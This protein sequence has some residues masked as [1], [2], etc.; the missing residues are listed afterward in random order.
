MS[1]DHLITL[2]KPY[3]EYVH[4][5]FVEHPKGNLNFDSSHSVEGAR[6]FL[7]P[8]YDTAS[9]MSRTTLDYSGVRI[10][11]NAID[12]CRQLFR[13]GVHLDRV[14]QLENA[15]LNDITGDPIFQDE[16]LLGGL[17][18]LLRRSPRGSG[19]RYCL[20]NSPMGIQI[21]VCSYFMPYRKKKLLEEC[22]VEGR[23][24]YEIIPGTHLKIQIQPRILNHYTDAQIQELFESVAN[25]FMISQPIPGNETVGLFWSYLKCEIHL[26]VDF[27][28]W[29]PTLDFLGNMVC[30]TGKLRLDESPNFV[31]FKHHAVVYGKEF[32]TATLGVREL[33]QFSFYRKDLRAIK[34]G[35]LGYW[36]DL[37]KSKCPDFDPDMKVW[38][39]ELRFHSNTIDTLSPLV[40]EQHIAENFIDQQTH[41]CNHATLEGMEIRY[42][43]EYKLCSF[44]QVKNYL[45]AFWRYGLTKLYRLVYDYANG[46]DNYHPIWTILINEVTWEGRYIDLK[47]F[48]RTVEDR[49]PEKTETKNV[50]FSLSHMVAIRV[51]N[52][53]DICSSTQQIIGDLENVVND[54]VKSLR[55]VRWFF[56]TVVAVYERRAGRYWWESL[57]EHITKL[58]RKR[59]LSE[60]AMC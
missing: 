18:F 50:Q 57:I 38:R 36:Q 4:D 56:P 15:I 22:L 8:V 48:K 60:H 7:T 31:D 34:E 32:E 43:N 20:N 37:W 14:Q 13:G 12:T 51:R 59:V 2:T 29:N 3:D 55:E 39:A 11:H 16:H 46:V 23:E 47:R 40:I 33:H 27:Q 49:D 6:Y 53:I 58:F 21:L 26:C 41:S 10:L 9:A 28:G 25:F 44:F 42:S 24:E 17:E 45:P 54:F 19:F 35:V 52:L 1:H 30:R 5:Y